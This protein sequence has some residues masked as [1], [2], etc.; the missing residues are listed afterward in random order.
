MSKDRIVYIIQ[1]GIPPTHF[2]AP[3]VAGGRS[4]WARG[5]VGRHQAE[6]FPTR[7]AAEAAAKK[8]AKFP[9]RGN[10]QPMVVE[11]TEQTKFVLSAVGHR[12][13]YWL[14]YDRR[15]A[16]YSWRTGAPAALTT[17]RFDTAEQARAVLGSVR[18]GA[19]G[20]DAAIIEQ[21]FLSD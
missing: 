20:A 13:T 9:G 14:Q 17:C 4:R 1:I 18:Q 6:R 21:T 5:Q 7:A 11:A 10:E 2:W 15:N 3:G 8:S 19:G 12:A 16:R